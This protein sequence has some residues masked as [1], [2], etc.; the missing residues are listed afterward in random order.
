LGLLRL[1]T[2]GTIGLHL[3]L[4]DIVFVDPLIDGLLTL[5]VHVLGVVAE[6]EQG[7]INLEL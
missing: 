5:D 6:R 7:C 1:L 3:D 4:S 2:L